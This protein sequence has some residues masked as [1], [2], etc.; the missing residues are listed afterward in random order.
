L[1]PVDEGRV[2][3]AITIDSGYVGP[4]Y[5]QPQ[6]SDI[7]TIREAGREEGLIL[8]TCYTSK[9]FRGFLEHSQPDETS[10]FVHTGGSY[11]LFPHREDLAAGTHR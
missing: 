4:G 9:A 1:E 3:D 11:G 2:R 7:A 6:E 10:L 8:D 5:A